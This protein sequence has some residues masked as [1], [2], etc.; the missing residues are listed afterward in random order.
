MRAH[1][2]DTVLRL[3]Q[4]QLISKTIKRDSS[5]VLMEGVCTGLTPSLQSVFSLSQSL[6]YPTYKTGDIVVSDLIRNSLISGNTTD[7]GDEIV[8]K[9]TPTQLGQAVLASSLPPDAALFV[10][11]DLQRAAKALAID[12][13][14]HMLYLVTPANCSIWQGCDW[15]NL[16]KIFVTLEADSK[17]IAKM[18]GANEQ[19]IIGRVQQRAIQSTDRDLQL[20]LRF[21]SSLALFDLVNEKSLAEVANRFQIPRGSLQTL[22]QQSATYAA[23]VVAFCSRLGWQYFRSLLDNFALRLAFGVRAELTELVRI[24]GIDGSRARIFHEKNISS[25]AQL[26]NSTLEEVTNVLSLAVPYDDSNVNDGKN[27]WLLGEERTTLIEAAEILISRAEQLVQE[28]LKSLGFNMSAIVIKRKDRVKDDIRSQKSIAPSQQEASKT[29]SSQE[30][31]SSYDNTTSDDNSD[32]S[33]SFIKDSQASQESDQGR[34]SPMEE[35]NQ[36]SFNDNSDSFED[37]SIDLFSNTLLELSLNDSV[38]LESSQGATSLGIQNGEVDDLETSLML[39]HSI[40]RST[41]ESGDNKENA[42]FEDSFDIPLQFKSP[43]LPSWS[44]G[45]SRRLSNASSL[46]TVAE[47]SME[48]KNTS[49]DL[50]D[51]SPLANKL[52]KRL[53]RSIWSPS[54]ASPISKFSRRVP[55]FPA[56]SLVVNDVCSSSSMWRQFVSRSLNWT[57]LGVSIITDKRTEEITAIALCGDDSVDFLPLADDYYPGNSTD[58]AIAPSAT[59]DENI[60][61]EM[62]KNQL[63]IILTSCTVHAFD[64]LEVGMKIYK[65]LSI[66]IEK[67]HCIEFLSFLALYRNGE[68]PIPLNQLVSKFDWTF[69][70]SSHFNRGPRIKCTTEAFVLSQLFDKIKPIAVKLSSEQSIS[71]ETSSVSVF[72][73]MICTGIAFSGARCSKELDNIRD[74]M[75]ILEAECQSIAHRAFNLDSPSQVSEVLFSNLKIPHPGGRGNTRHLPTNKAVLESLKPEYPIVEKILTFRSLK[76][77]VTQ[78]L[79]PLSKCVDVDG[80]IRTSM[81]ICTATGRILSNRPNIQTVPKGKDEFSFSGRSLFATSSQYSLIAADYCQLELRVLAH[82]SGDKLLCSRLGNEERDFFKD[83]SREW[84]FSRD[85]VKQLCYGIIYGMGVRSLADTTSSTVENAQKLIDSFFKTFPAV[86][87]YI[88]N[89][90]EMS[91]KAGFVTTV[92]GRRRLTKSRGKQDEKAQDDRQSMNFTIQG[93]ASEIFKQALLN[94]NKSIIG[95]DCHLVMTV[96]DEVLVECH[97]SILDAVKEKIKSSMQNVFPLRV[98]LRVKV[99]SGPDWG[100]LS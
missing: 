97:N 50:F 59:P 77:T 10:F 85:C 7:D 34:S 76:H 65:S 87:S 9:L 46:N 95:M 13:E 80:R 82:L 57:S 30:D 49:V 54:V 64:A 44:Q 8:S 24:E 23:M 73:R 86:Q 92:L 15:H 4:P 27:E 28:Q 43:C 60:T 84:G 55:V 52:K 36:S 100:S 74:K 38:Q 69:D 81:L 66:L 1:E 26:S 78:C 63:S 47:T 12:T 90:K 39:S 33:A 16:H 71:L 42:V 48:E 25:L 37:A 35:N 22:Q 93:T 53:S 29:V 6:L 79:L 67:I 3:I 19:F 32:L 88:N 72:L 45:N 75:N 99:I 56:R 31:L 2:R 5:K 17:R 40:L 61:N 62:K 94:I 41:N 51:D 98:P 11:S 20:H 91:S 89:T 21:F 14:L 83:L 58:E 96:H 68:N 18:V 70:V